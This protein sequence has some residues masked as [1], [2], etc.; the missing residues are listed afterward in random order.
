MPIYSTITNAAQL[1]RIGDPETATLDFKATF[2]THEGENERICKS[3]AAFA[4][5]F[6]GSLVIGADDEK[7][8]YLCKYMNVEEPKRLIQR[9]QDV[10]NNRLS[11]RH[12]IHPIEL[13]TDG[14]TVV[15][16]NVDPSPTLIAY[17][18]TDGAWRFP[19]RTG[20][21]TALLLFEEVERMISP[22]RRA[23]LMLAAI[24]P[25]SWVV[26]DHAMPRTKMERTNSVTSKVNVRHEPGD[27][28]NVWKYL[29]CRGEHMELEFH[30]P[31][32]GT[33]NINVPLIAV[34]AVWPDPGVNKD[35]I[36]ARCWIYSRPGGTGFGLSIAPML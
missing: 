17:E 30:P 29:G 13:Q 9:M 34:E 21:Q 3:V 15:V 16:V 27:V 18:V 4:N 33:F 14:K 31:E 1:P 20:R 28:G 26:F 10:T 24:R 23:R 7:T 19:I 25:G 8:D 6:G 36:A 11:P 5:A 32:G 22:T 2:G 12:P 35:V